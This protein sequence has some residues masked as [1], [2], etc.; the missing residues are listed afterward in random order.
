ML[1]F[2][3]LLV[4]R[5]KSFPQSQSRPVS[6][7]YGDARRG[8]STHRRD[9]TNRCARAAPGPV[10]CEVFLCRAVALVAPNALGSPCRSMTVS[11]EKRSLRWGRGRSA[12][13][14]ETCRNTGGPPPSGARKPKPRSSF[15]R[16]KVPDLRSPVTIRRPSLH[17][18]RNPTVFVAGAGQ[19][20]A[21]A[22]RAGGAGQAAAV[23]SVGVSRA[24]RAGPV[25]W[26]RARVRPRASARAGR[27]PC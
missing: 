4:G 10:R 25:P 17:P 9:R 13:R 6:P 24:R 11:K 5:H 1:A 14:A 2:R 16:T 7:G 18:Y 19:A 15:Q 22:R 20:R 12:A 21:R 27:R 26:T 3:I 23:Q 8:P